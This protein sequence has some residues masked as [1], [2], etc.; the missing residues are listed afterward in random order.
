MARL[1]I[2]RHGETEWNREEHFRGRAE[3]DLTER[4]V[5]Q[6]AAAAQ[7]LPSWQPA[8]I[9]SSPLKRAWRT[10]QILAQPTS[11]PL[12][13]L[14]GLIDIDY[15]QWQGLSPQ[16]AAARDGELYWQ[17]RHR[18]HLVKFPGGEGLAEV[19]ARVEAAVDFLRQ[20]HPQQTVVLVSH[21]VV[22]KVMVLALLG[23]DN[24]RFWQIEQEVGA[25]N[26]FDERP[27]YWMAGLIND[28]CH[29][30]GVE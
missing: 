27:P 30:K 7:R 8:L 6:A 24:S 22:C 25:I 9:Y 11:L 29:L 15:G 16:E 3:L 20:H 26:V 18:P 5:R 17:W 14:E 13:P 12:H 23:L 28:T 4:G 2:V 19:R 10:A 21:Q 1:V